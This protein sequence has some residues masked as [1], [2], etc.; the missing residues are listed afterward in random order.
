MPVLLP[1]K[2]KTNLVRTSNIEVTNNSST[3]TVYGVKVID[4]LPPASQLENVFFSSPDGPYNP[5][6]G[7]WDV[8]LPP[9]ATALLVVDA[10]VPLTAASG[11]LT[12][13]AVVY[14]PDGF[15]DPDCPGT[16]CSGNNSA[17]DTNTITGSS[18]SS[19]N[20]LLVKRITAI[21]GDPSSNPND[22]TPL[23]QIE[24]LTTGPQAQDDN[25]PHWLDNY[26]QGSIQ[27]GRVKPEDLVDYKIYFLSAGDKAAA[28]VKVCDRIPQN[29]LFAPTTFGVEQGI[30]VEVGGQTLT[31]TNRLDGDA[32]TFYSP[33]ES[34]P[35]FCGVDGSD[36]N[37]NPTGAIVVDLG[38]L[39]K[40]T[41][42]GTPSNS[43]GFINFRATVK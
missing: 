14:P 4:I 37:I 18:S 7:E 36:P 16:V 2:L 21:N 33:G 22:Q 34:L 3:V 41:S 35:S 29:Q 12:N 9:G 32:A 42:S 26:L 19:P 15:T 8:T 13:T 25:H 31:Y 27:G 43:Y 10:A 39:P 23:D 1:I 30:Q 20:V 17:T 40:S 11:S 5:A 6:N 24:N 28:K 38:T